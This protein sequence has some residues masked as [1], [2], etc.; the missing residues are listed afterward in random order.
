MQSFGLQYEYDGSAHCV[1]NTM[2]F[3]SEPTSNFRQ[4]IYSPSDFAAISPSGNIVAVYMKTSS[5]NPIANLTAK[6]EATGLNHMFNT[7]NLKS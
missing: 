6:M 7:L 1:S 5:G 3:T 4:L 2:L